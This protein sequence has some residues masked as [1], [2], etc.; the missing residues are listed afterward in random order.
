MVPAN[1]QRGLCSVHRP[2]EASVLCDVGQGHHTVVVGDQDDVD[3]GQIQQFSLQSVHTETNEAF[4]QL[5]LT[6]TIGKQNYCVANVYFST[7]G[8]QNS[9]CEST[10]TLPAHSFNSWKDK[11]SFV[12]SS[13]KINSSLR[14]ASPSKLLQPSPSLLCHPWRPNLA[15]WRASG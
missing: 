2:S 14:Q 10:N 1:L 8:R 7:S 12:S 11:I 13:K 15:T 3:G 9:G 5:T 6:L 4:G